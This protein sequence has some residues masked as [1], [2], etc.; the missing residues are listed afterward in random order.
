MRFKIFAC[1]SAMAAVAGVVSASGTA[2][3]KAC[4]RDSELEAAVGEQVRA[5]R[6]AIDASMLRDA[7]M[8]SG[9][10]VAQAIQRLAQRLT[11]SVDPQQ[12]SPVPSDDSASVQR[13]P[14]TEYAT[15]KGVTSDLGGLLDF[16]S[17]PNCETGPRFSTF[18]SDLVDYPQ[19]IAADVPQFGKVTVP[20]A[21]RSAIGNP[22]PKRNEH[23]LAVHVPIRGQWLGLSVVALEGHYW[24]GGDSG[25]FAIVFRASA[26][27]AHTKLNRAGFNIPPSGSRTIPGGYDNTI[28]LE[29]NGNTVTL[30]CM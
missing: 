23:G 19:D 3:A 15:A 22:Q 18:L 9:T 8:C 13:L 28:S 1:Y 29:P 16:A 10:T 6:F 25:G 12:P 11:P 4:I 30:F 24:N 20:P 27:E 5:G 2:S 17:R 26:A 14:T 7:R 21:Y